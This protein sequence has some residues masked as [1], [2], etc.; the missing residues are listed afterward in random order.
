MS[1]CRVT[2]DLAPLIDAGEKFGAIYADPPWEYANEGTRSAAGAKYNTMALGGIEAMPVGALAAESCH[3]HL[4]ATSTLLPQALS[5]MAAWGFEYKS[6]CVWVKPRIGMGN[7][8][9]VSHEFLLLGVRGPS[10][11]FADKGL[12]S[13]HEAPRLKHSQKPEVFRLMVERA[14]PGPYL[15]L[16]SRRVSAGWTV[17]GNEVEGDLFTTEERLL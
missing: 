8:W 14:S 13:W 16:F 1:L 3:L 11:L 15:E 10:A 17:F 5:V 12:R 7:Y 6:S 4:W 2:P 9:R